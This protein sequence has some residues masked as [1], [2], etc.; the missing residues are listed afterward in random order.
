MG[1]GKWYY[2]AMPT[3][4]AAPPSGGDRPESPAAA[5]QYI[6]EGRMAKILVVDDSAVD[7][8]AMIG[9]LQKHGYSVV[10]AADGKQALEQLE[11]ERPDLMLLDVI[12]P[13]VNGFQLCRDLRRDPRY[14]RLPIVLVTSKNQ[15]ADRHWGMKQ[16]A[17]DY[18]PKP[19]TAEQLVATV[20]RLV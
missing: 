17:S 10:V 7:R 4:T 18:L 1:R 2:G 9:P 15:P 5:P 3:G 19:F 13:G 14:A 6:P 20:R 11:R 12:M 16:G 8:M